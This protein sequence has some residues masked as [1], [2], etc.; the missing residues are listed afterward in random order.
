MAVHACGLNSVN[1][2]SPAPRKYSPTDTL[3]PFC[4]QLHNPLGLITP[5]DVVLELDASTATLAIGGAVS[6]VLTWKNPCVGGIATMA[7]DGSCHVTPGC[8]SDLQ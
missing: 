2:H 8:V 5:D 7:P 1:I 4:P 3:A 6:L